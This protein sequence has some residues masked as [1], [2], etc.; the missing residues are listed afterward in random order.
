MTG[1]NAVLHIVSANDLLTGE[2]RYLSD[3]GEWSPQ[4]TTARLLADNGAAVSLLEEVE[5]Q[6]NV[7]TDA[8]MIEVTLNEQGILT[9]VRLREIIRSS[10]PTVS[11]S[12]ISDITLSA[13][14]RGVNH[15]PV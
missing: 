4:L 14:Q 7:V 12:Q 6:T 11:A 3:Y 5:H 1:K 15:V 8:Y 9:P 2:V 10:G 13:R